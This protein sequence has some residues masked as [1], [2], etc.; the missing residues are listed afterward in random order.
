M[1]RTHL[2]DHPWQGQSSPSGKYSLQRRTLSQEAGG[3]KDIGTWGGGHPFDLEA[4]RLPPGKMNFPYHAHSAQWE[5]YYILSGSGQMKTPAGLYD[6]RQG[7]YLVC[8]PDEPHQLI[9]TTREDLVYLVIANQPQADV[10]HYPNSGK[11]LIKPQKKIF[12]MKE[13]DYFQGEE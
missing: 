7:D 2:D 6:I 3:K 8:P 10:I 9:N 13:V 11:W 12:E 4:H 5:A 1:T